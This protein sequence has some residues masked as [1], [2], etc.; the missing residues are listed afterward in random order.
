MKVIEFDEKCRACKGTGLYV[1]I[2]ERDGSAVV[3]HTCN[4]TG[5]HHFKYEYEDFTERIPRADVNQV[6]QVNPGII[7]GKGAQGGYVLSDFGGMSYQDW[8]AGKPFEAGMEMR[9]FVC[10]AWWYQS[11]DYK[12]KPDW[13]E[14]LA[15]G[16]FSGCSS[17]K[18]KERCWARWDK[19]FGEVPI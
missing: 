16:S 5:C 8:Q 9:R 7:I 4:G 2:A 3:C 17:F 11:A 15:C 12:K 10:P 19:E 1:G 18:T 14:C 6:V 13:D